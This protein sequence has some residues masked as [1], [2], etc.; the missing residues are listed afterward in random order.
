MRLV[1]RSE[2]GFA[3]LITLIILAL[4]CLI[5]FYLGV[6]AATEIRV[7]DN[8]EAEVQARSAAYAGLDHARA[9]LR[10]LDFTTL[11]Q[12]PDGQYDADPAN[13]ARARALSYRNPIPFSL[14]RALDIRDPGADVGSLPDEG[15]LSTGNYLSSPASVFIPLAGIA[16]S[17]PRPGA[18]GDVVAARYFV[19]VTD[20]NGEPS[21]R[22]ADSLDNP[23]VDGD[24]LILVRSVGVAPSTSHLAGPVRNNSVVVFEARF[25]RRQALEPG[26]ALVLQ[27]TSVQPL[28]AAVFEGNAFLI[29]GGTANPGIGT[30]DTDG[31]DAVNP[32]VDVTAQ[33]ASGQASHI[34]G[35]GLHPS[36]LDLTPDVASDPQR[37]PLQDRD[38]LWSLLC[39]TG[40][41]YADSRYQGDQD[42]SSGNAPDLGSYDAALP[43]NAPGQRPRLTFVDGNVVL[44]GGAAGGGLLVVTGRLTVTGPFSFTG[45]VF[46][47]GIGELSISGSS[48]GIAGGIHVANLVAAGKSRAW[49]SVHLSIGGSGTLTYDRAAIRMAIALIPPEQTGFRE[50]TSSLD[51]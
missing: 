11:L 4:F 37:A 50:I 1:V 46:V 48:W 34:Q 49:G 22:A 8:Y 33:V 16:L 29:Q 35:Q 28:G 39:V 42:W 30:L 9:A 31:S 51:P 21:E 25:R 12:G 13:I 14:A 40:A 43:M 41:K 6:N 17:T 38:F 3:L 20:N 47:T 26:A 32:M 36:I 10:G 44:G 23:F 15:V 27:G 24:G 45:L 5:G 19:K 7:S 2:R 18:P